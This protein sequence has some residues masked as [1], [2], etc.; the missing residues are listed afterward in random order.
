[1][2]LVCYN[3]YKQDRQRLS[4]PHSFLDWIWSSCIQRLHLFET[5]QNPKLLPGPGMMDDGNT[6]VEDKPI[7]ADDTMDEEISR[8]SSK[9]STR[10]KR[11]KSSE[12]GE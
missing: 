9:G 7:E 12:D 5:S 11:A 6:K 10:A 4:L 8:E 3:A 1:M 2:I